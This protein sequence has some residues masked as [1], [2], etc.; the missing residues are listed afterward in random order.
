[1]KSATHSRIIHFVVQDV[2]QMEAGNFFQYGG[3]VCGDV[4]EIQPA[5]RVYGEHINGEPQNNVVDRKV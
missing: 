5:V 4:K 2:A 3:P 1:M